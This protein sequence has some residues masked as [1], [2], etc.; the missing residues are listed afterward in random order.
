MDQVYFRLLASIEARRLVIFTGAGLSMSEPTLLPS[1]RELA[2]EAA[3]RH[4]AKTGEILDESVREDI[5]AQARLFHAS[6]QLQTYF[7]P[8]LIDWTGFA[9]EPNAGHYAVADLLLS[10][11]LAINVTTNVD[12]LVEK[13]A[14]ALGH[15]R[16]DVAIS[17]SQAAVAR[18]HP[19]FLKIH[20]CVR[21]PADTLWCRE[22][23]A[24]PPWNMR[25]AQSA[26]WLAGGLMQKD[27]IFVGFWSDW[28]YLNEV[29]NRVLVDQTP[30]SVTLVDPADGAV[31]AAKAKDLWDWAHGPDIEF[32]HVQMSG[33]DFLAELRLRYSR[34]LLLQIAAR[35]EQVFRER[36]GAPPPAFPDM[37]M[38]S[39]DQLYDLRRD[40]S[41]VSRRSAVLRREPQSAD[42]LLGSFFYE[43]V[44]AGAV[45]DGNLIE[46]RGERIRLVQ[47]AGRPLYRV[48][49]ELAKGLHPGDTPD[50]TVCVAADDDG[51][52]AGNV[53]RP[54][55]RPSIVR[56]N[57]GGEWY[58]HVR[59]R[60]HLGLG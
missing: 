51:G 39:V 26:Q 12:V 32:E 33:S 1:A 23:L 57:L 42:E 30:R 44:S 19:P 18:P 38:C 25:I 59:A 35:G 58:S 56:G 8:H 37:S 31:L 11:A 47:G 36:T 4:A 10:H 28:P 6:K 5:E 15:E 55:R 41:G 13:A 52:A 21:D 50:V 49:E 53:L 22:Q 34:L 54:A 24:E 27:L 46:A 2:R 7:L 43:L 60:A 29:L 9:G 40:W 20:G 3:R 45:L 14:G 16:L 48:Q 17:G